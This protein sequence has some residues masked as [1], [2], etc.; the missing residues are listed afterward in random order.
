MGDKIQQQLAQLIN[1]FQEQRAANIATWEAI[2][3]FLDALTKDLVNSK[4]DSYKNISYKTKL[5]LEE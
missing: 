5:G 2:N 4:V 3:A 1:L